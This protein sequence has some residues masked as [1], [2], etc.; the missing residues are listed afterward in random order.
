MKDTK[1]QIYVACL[2]AYNNGRLHGKW[3]D[4]DQDAEAIQAEVDA[5][6][7]H[8]PQPGAEEWAIHD[9]EGFEGIRLSESEPFERVSELAELLAEHGPAYAAYVAHVG[10]D[11]ATD[12]E[13]AYQ[14]EWDSEEDFGA[15]LYN[16]CYEALPD[17][18]PLAFYLDAAIDAWASD[19]FTAGDYFSADTGN[20]TVYVFRNV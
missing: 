19:L 4:A 13:D 17:G 18:H 7:A 9:Y 8:S 20:G 5:M 12:F 3:I 15:D 1:R 2:S 14:G 16:S 6:L 11:Y 10:A